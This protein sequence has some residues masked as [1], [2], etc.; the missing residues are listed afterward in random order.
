MK[1]TITCPDCGKTLEVSINELVS[2]KVTVTHKVTEEVNLGAIIKSI[3]DGEPEK[4]LYD[5]AEVTIHLK[6]GKEL[7]LQ[8]IIGLYEEGQVIFVAKGMPFDDIYMNEENTNK[9]GWRD[10]NARK[11]LSSSIL[12]EL[13]DELVAAI[14][15]R[16][17]V[18]NLR[19]KEYVSED[20]LWMMSATEVFG[21][22]YGESDS[23]DDKQF[24]IFQNYRDRIKFDEDGSA[25][26]WWLRSPYLSKATHFCIVD[27]NGYSYDSS[28]SNSYGVCFGFCINKKKD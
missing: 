20:K 11:V 5:G 6:N 16:K 19:G 27:G 8:T 15:P 17:I 28:A 9:G 1:F 12:A 18:Q 7:V 24:P 10:S 14:S 4:Y 26:Y 13:P 2:N 23:K 25:S 21:D 3:Q 22:N